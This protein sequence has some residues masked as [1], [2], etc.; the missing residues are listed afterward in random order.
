MQGTVADL[1]SLDRGVNGVSRGVTD[2]CQNRLRN[3]H[4]FA[5]AGHGGHGVASARAV[6]AVADSA[7]CARPDCERANCNGDMRTHV[8]RSTM[9]GSQ[10]CGYSSLRRST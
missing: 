5:P 6:A 2:T 7:S 3:Y 4:D 10:R 8:Q 9:H 1:L